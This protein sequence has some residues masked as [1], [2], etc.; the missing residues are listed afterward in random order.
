MAVNVTGQSP[1]VAHNNIKTNAATWT[2][3]AARL[4][5]LNA[6]PPNILRPASGIGGTYLCDACSPGSS[7]VA[8]ACPPYRA[9]CGSDVIGLAG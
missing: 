4:A 8:W 5:V 1:T 9:A 3:S 7:R 6:H 2:N